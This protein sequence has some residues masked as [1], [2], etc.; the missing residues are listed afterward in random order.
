[1]SGYQLGLAILCLNAVATVTLAAADPLEDAPGVT[2]AGS[3]APRLDTATPAVVRVGDS[4]GL[5][6]DHFGSDAERVTVFVGGAE[7]LVRACEDGRIE[8][9]V[10]CGARDGRVVVA[11][12]DPRND[13]RWSRAVRVEIEDPI[14][15]DLAPLRPLASSPDGLS[16]SMVMVALAPLE[17]QGT[18]TELLA[19][20][21]GR[22]VRWHATRNLWTIQLPEEGGQEA[23]T[24]LMETWARDP[25]VR[26]TWLTHVSSESHLQ[27]P[28]PA[29]LLGPDGLRVEL[30]GDAAWPVLALVD[31]GG[32]LVGVVHGSVRFDWRLVVLDR[33][34]RPR[35]VFG[36]FWQV[37]LE[38]EWEPRPWPALFMDVQ[39]RP[40]EPGGASGWLLEESSSDGAVDE[41]ESVLRDPAGTVRATSG[42]Y[43]D[44]GSEVLLDV[45][46]QPVARH[47][48]VEVSSSLWLELTRSGCGASGAS[49]GVSPAVDCDPQQE[50]HE[51]VLGPLGLLMVPCLTVEQ[52]R[53][54]YEDPEDYLHCLPE[55][56]SP[57]RPTSEFFFEDAAGERRWVPALRWDH[58]LPE[59]RAE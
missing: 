54:G 12:H 3:V 42:W 16:D 11:R 25:R 1:M 57:Y 9:V 8:A 35:I 46:G 36:R 45:S 53:E 5:V 39:G 47:E 48:T 40:V 51:V 59:V 6:G 41:R 56:G 52:L 23:G 4:I 22:A 38:P 19:G 37:D 10:P 20:S 50:S 29:S 43:G 58:N 34:H 55:A 18:L 17:C 2:S 27:P 49:S 21:E 15:P 24:R 7:A 32:Q 33:S 14:D 28:P 30:A 44:G 13:L 26:Q 31:D